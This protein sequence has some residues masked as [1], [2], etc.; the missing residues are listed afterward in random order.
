[1]KDANGVEEV[2][3]DL[4]FER[5]DVI[6]AGFEGEPDDPYGELRE[7]PAIAGNALNDLPRMPAVVM[8]EDREARPFPSDPVLLDSQ[9]RSSLA[10]F[11]SL[12]HTGN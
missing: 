7:D 9:A 10:R 3:I 1:M 6:G 4:V 12:A 11:R 5:D 8:G 2:P